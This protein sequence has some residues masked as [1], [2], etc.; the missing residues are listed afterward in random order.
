[1]LLHSNITHTGTVSHTNKKSFSNL[2]YSGLYQK[3]ADAV[4]LCLIRKWEGM[5]EEL[6]P[7]MCQDICN[8]KQADRVKICDT[9]DLESTHSWSAMHLA[10]PLSCKDW[11]SYKD[12]CLQALSFRK[13]QQS[14]KTCTRKADSSSLHKISQ[15]YTQDNWWS[16]TRLLAVV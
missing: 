15:R 8:V 4:I 7:L 1:M 11:Y 16:K 5:V 12:P 13:A 2:D 9:T 3:Y 14:N 10:C 6:A